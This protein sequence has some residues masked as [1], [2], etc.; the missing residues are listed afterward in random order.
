M[1]NKFKIANTNSSFLGLIGIVFFLIIWQFVGSNGIINPLFISYP[2]QIA[3]SLLYFFSSG[4]IYS[5]IFISMQEFLIGYIVAILLGVLVGILI[6]WYK[7]IYGFTNIFIIVL[8]VTPVV[9]FIPLLMLW[10]GITLWSKIV[11]V[12]L[13]AFF[14]IVIN[15]STG[16]KATN[17]EFVK[18]ARSFGANDF[19]LFTTVAI[20]SSFPYILSGM[21]LAAGRAL[22]GVVVSELYGSQ[23]GLGY[24]LTLFG[25]TFQT[26]R[27]MASIFII[28]LIGVTVIGIIQLIEKR[29][30][31]NQE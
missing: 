21:R 15:T 26:D 28:T 1:N 14:P 16:I 18:V 11:I 17:P 23:G 29:L 13:F 3:T 7:L 12:A 10:L 24:L 20:P 2:S 9:A 5:H 27:L 30:V 31:F 22:I 8:Y 19:K 6:G 25:S 4:F